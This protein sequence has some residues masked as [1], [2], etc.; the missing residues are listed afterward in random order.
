MA[1]S[2][3]A[4]IDSNVL[5]KK[6]KME[7]VE[8]KNHYT[9]ERAAFRDLL[10]DLTVERMKANPS[11][12]FYRLMYSNWLDDHP[13]VPTKCINLEIEDLAEEFLDKGWRMSKGSANT[14]V[15]ERMGDCERWCCFL[16]CCGFFRSRA[17]TLVFGEPTAKVATVSYNPL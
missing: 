3:P 10:I 11:I 15:L 17:W 7:Q 9:Q 4:S 16:C 8:P 14:I 5:K 12:K 13:E 1:S 2:L 6:A